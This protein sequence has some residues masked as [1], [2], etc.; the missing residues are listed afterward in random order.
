MQGARCVIFFAAI[1]SLLTA[2]P[3]GSFAQATAPTNTGVLAKLHTERQAPTD[4]EIDGDLAALQSGSR[5]YLTR[6]DLLSLPQITYTVTGDPNFTKATAVSGILLETL[7]RELAASPES[8]LAIAVCADQYRAHYPR[9]YLDAH[10]PLLVLKVNGQPPERWP[11]D[12]EGHGLTMGPY[13]ITH[14]Q[15]TPTYKILAHQDEPQIPWAVTRLEFRSEKTVF[16]AIAPHGV[17]A[18]NA[19]VQDGYRIAQQNCFRCHNMAGDGGQKARRPWLVLSAWATASPEYFAAYVRDPK[20]RN[21]QAQMYANP[22]YDDAT[23]RA[24]TAY[25]RTFAGQE[26]P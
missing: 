26:K 4:L 22:G 8:D 12:A 24:L 13:M 15:F 16:G 3:R 25:F 23:I 7:M 9:A 2:A 6:D 18:E 10:H 14:R 19:S 21:P 11:K 17:D 20:S 5:R 1:V